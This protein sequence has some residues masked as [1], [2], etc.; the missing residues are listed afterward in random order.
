[1]LRIQLG[2]DCLLIHTGSSHGERASTETPIPKGAQPGIGHSSSIDSPL[3]TRNTC[4]QRPAYCATEGGVIVDRRPRPFTS[5]CQSS[6]HNR[7]KSNLKS[8]QDRHK[9]PT[10][11]L[12]SYAV[13]LAS[14]SPQT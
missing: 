6:V 14:P 13:R 11:R 1:M 10:G 4:S 2:L 8:Q 12:A 9:P 3:L 7:R 5:D